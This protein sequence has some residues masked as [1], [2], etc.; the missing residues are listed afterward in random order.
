M[1]FLELEK[2][3]ITE[4]QLQSQMYWKYGQNIFRAAHIIRDDPR[5]NAI[6]LS[7]FSCGPDSFI[8]TLFKELMTCLDN[9]GNEFRK[10]VLV[11]EIDEHSADA[12]VI[13]RLEAFHESLKAADK[14]HLS[15]TSAKPADRLPVSP[16]KKQWDGCSERTIYLP[17]MGDRSYAV[18]AAFQYSG[19]NAE[20]L[21]VADDET[22]RWGRKFTSGKEC[23]P[24]I[25]TTGD[26][27]KKIAEPSFEPS[28]AAFFMPGA[29]G[30][31]RF[32]QYNCLQRLVL[33]QVG[34]P[35]NIPIISPNQDSRFYESMQRF[36]KDPFTLAF[37]GMISVDLLFKVLLKTRPYETKPAQADVT[38]HKCL[39]RILS[40]VRK[41]A[42]M[43]LLAAEMKTCAELFAAIPLDKT[44]SKPVIGV[45]GEIYVRNHTFANY[46]IIRQLEKLGAEVDLA[47]FT[48]WLYYTNLTRMLMAQS[49]RNP[50]EFLQNL[51]KNYFQHK[52][53]KQLAKP[54]EKYFGPL[55]EG[56]IRDVI[57]LAAP[58]IHESFQGEAILSVGKMI[59]MYHHGAAG[60][61]SVGPFT[62][63][64]SNIVTTVA[65]QVSADCQTM[66]II[67]ISYDGQQD[68]TLQTRLE[69]FIHQVKNFKDQ[70]I[71]SLPRGQLAART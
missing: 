5:L 24:C 1:D 29:S 27:L 39:K 16:W 46:D 53:E 44:L 54:L 33:K 32:G 20:V 58:Y 52:I 47:T 28:K 65:R 2:A 25:I 41:G 31:C 67:S 60:A 21:P 34:F 61:V 37:K 59:Q 9:D 7:N 19:Q 45:V 8:I 64:P 26:M 15:L 11:L 17:W 55:A 48:E 13:T 57:E 14:Q 10:P 50:K 43:N 18:Q 3:N 69:A 4:P 42:N 6:F 62:C 70:R 68:P 35:Q 23:L 30:P 22:L 51:I 40:A 36:K 12:G 38:Y 49:R 63:M 56:D 66:P 71:K